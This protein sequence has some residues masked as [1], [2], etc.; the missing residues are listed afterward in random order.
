MNPTNL[1]SPAITIPTHSLEQ[2]KRLG[3]ILATYLPA[4]TIALQGT[5]GAGKTHLA[6][7]IAVGCGIPE[8]DVTSPTFVI[9]QQYMGKRPLLHADLYRLKDEDEFWELGAEEWFTLPG[10]VLIEWADKF[11]RCLPVDHLQIEILVSGPD[12]RTFVL[13]PMGDF[14]TAVLK[15]IELAWTTQSP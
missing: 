14:P 3:Q 12:S 6:K 2:T 10:L 5:L 4:T 1:P 15:E 9:C 13:R 8:D 7:A 11:P